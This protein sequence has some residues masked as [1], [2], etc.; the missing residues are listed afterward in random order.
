M[1]IPEV[2]YIETVN[3]CNARCTM[4]PH[5]KMK[6]EQGVMPNLIFEKTIQSLKELDLSEVQLF[7]HKEGEP[8]LDPNIVDRIQY[9]KEH[10]YGL[11]ELGINTNAM[12]LTEDIS[13]S[14]LQSGLDTIYFSIDGASAQTYNKIRIGLNYDVVESNVAKFFSLRKKYKKKINVIMQM[15]TNKDNYH[16]VELFKQR[17][18][19]ESCEF[20]I[21]KMHCYLDGGNSSFQQ[22]KSSTQLNI[23][24]DPFKMIVIYINGD[25]GTCCWDYE[26]TYKIGNIMDFSVRELFNNEPFK[27]L[28]EMQLKKKCDI[29]IPCN[30]CMRV[31]GNDVITP[32]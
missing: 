19:H 8:L 25:A 2:V 22:D 4:C 28:R 3:K 15:V 31:Y 12:L 23:C 1:L 32:G 27:Y 16:E 6:R 7:L 9:A 10:L 24:Q 20:Y 11:Q 13:M 14:L 26:N 30:R 29:I 18:Q 21:K 5:P 17:W